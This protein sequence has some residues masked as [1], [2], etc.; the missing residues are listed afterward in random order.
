MA[1]KIAKKSAKKPAPLVV[2]VAR[3]EDSKAQYGIF[4][5][6]PYL[7][8]RLYYS[9]DPDLELVS[10]LCPKHF[11]PMMGITLRP[12]ERRQF[13]WSGSPLKPYV[14]AKRKAAKRAK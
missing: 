2:W 10:S 6:D 4:L 8:F 13:V 5:E 7:S 12:G 14:A 3:D 11:E 9:K 1:K